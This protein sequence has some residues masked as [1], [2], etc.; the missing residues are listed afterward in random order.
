MVDDNSQDILVVRFT[1]ENDLKTILLNRALE[2]RRQKP[3]SAVQA[4]SSN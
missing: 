1:D 2:I 3:A 4:N